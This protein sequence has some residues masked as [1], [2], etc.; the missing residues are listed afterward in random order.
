MILFFSASNRTQEYGSCYTQKKFLN[1]TGI[2]VN[3]KRSW[4]EAS[5]QFRLN[6]NVCWHQKIL[7]TSS[8]QLYK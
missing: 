2:L 1:E 7:F 4:Q 5:W 3:E 6:M 8:K